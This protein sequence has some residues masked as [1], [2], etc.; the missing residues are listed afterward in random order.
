L[1]LGVYTRLATNTAGSGRGPGTWPAPK[2]FLSGFPMHT[3]DRSVFLRYSRTAS[4]T[5]RT[6]VY[7]PVCTVVWQGSAGNCRP[8]DC[9]CMLV[10]VRKLLEI[11]CSLKLLQPKVGSIRNSIRLGS[12]AGGSPAQ[13]QATSGKR[14]LAL[15]DPGLTL[16]QPADVHE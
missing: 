13:D 9:A 5:S 1:Q 7:G 16:R 15:P 14:N 6:T 2:P 4:V 11:V 12:R 8:Y 3:S 10:C